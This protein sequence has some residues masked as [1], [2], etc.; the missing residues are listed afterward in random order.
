VATDDPVRLPIGAT[1]IAGTR[2]GQ[3]A[4]VVEVTAGTV[5]L[6]LS[7]GMGRSATPEPGS[8]PAVG[9][10][11]SYTAATDG[12]QPGA[13]FP[14]PDDTPW[15]HGGRPPAYEAAELGPDRADPASAEAIGPEA[16][17]EAWV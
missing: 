3:T 15:T 9:E 10:A 12:Y 17:T 6:E 7:G 11:I 1:L 2:P 5:V 13:S 4:T 16:A 14:S 8:L